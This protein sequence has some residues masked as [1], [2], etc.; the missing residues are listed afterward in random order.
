MIGELERCSWCRSGHRPAG[1][2]K[3]HLYDAQFRVGIPAVGISVIGMVDLVAGDKYISVPGGRVGR[4][5]T[6]RIL[7]LDH[8]GA[9]AFG[10]QL[11]ALVDIGAQD[12]FRAADDSAIIDVVDVA[13]CFCVVGTTQAMS[14][15]E[16]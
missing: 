11:A 4:I 15:K 8:D 9:A 2:V 1:L 3:W 12:I 7:S 10:Q 5:D 14:Y 6:A 13:S 16:I